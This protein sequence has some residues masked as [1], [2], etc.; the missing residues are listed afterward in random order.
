MNTVFQKEYMIQSRDVN[1]A[2]RLRP[3][4]FLQLFQEMA[5]EHSSAM[6][7]GYE[8]TH[9]NGLMWIIVK[10]HVIFHELPTYTDRVVLSTWVSD[11]RH[12][13]FPRYCRMARPDGT[14]LADCAS[15]FVLVDRNTRQ[16]VFPE[17]FDID[18]SGAPTGHE[19]SLPGRIRFP[20]LTQSASFTVPYSYIDLNGHMS[21]VRYLDLAE[22][23]LGLSE[24]GKHIEEFTV[25]YAGE[26]RLHETV[27]VSWAWEDG[28]CYMTGDT[29]RRN[30]N[31]KLK[32]S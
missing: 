30:F 22:D 27:T 10:N 11:R 32:F 5:G 20:E 25:E 18:H 13:L 21:N 31:L 4:A 1:M 7:C 28:V 29:D 3:S 16:A 9:P 2:S 26:V 15:Y 8:M 12:L 17:Q 24:T 6:G 14:P 23:V 19:I